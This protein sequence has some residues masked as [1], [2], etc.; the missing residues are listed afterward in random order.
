MPSWRS[1]HVVF[2][3]PFV[4]LLL[5]N[6]IA[7]IVLAHFVQLP[8]FNVKGSILL[9]NLCFCYTNNMLSIYLIFKK[10]FT[11]FNHLGCVKQTCICGLIKR[12]SGV[13]TPLWGKCEDETHTPKS[14]NLESS[15]T[16][17]TSK[18]DSRRQNTLPWGVFY[19]I[20]KVLKCRCRKWPRMSHSDICSTSYGQNK[21]WESNWQFDSR[22]QKV[23]NRP[24]P[25]VCRWS[26]TY[27]SKALEESYEIASD[28][29][30]IRGLN[31]ELWVPKVPRV[32]TRTVSGLLF[33]SPGN[34][35]H[36][37]AVAARQRRG[38]YM[39]EGG[40][41]P[42]VQAVVSQ[43]SPRSPVA[44]PNTKRGKMNSN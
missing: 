10:S 16:L 5:S 7:S 34:K 18:L 2:S 24:D 44:C 21:G 26:A 28:L 13:A 23:G 20:E 42:R 15:E 22:P 39:G 31:R 35:S 1:F 37:N 6:I 3:S 32:Q 33:G 36:F 9:I 43:V 38:Y 40:G 25:G 11:L 8:F 29:I 27:R 19:T 30:P 12:T 14:G 4:L 41:F 17:T